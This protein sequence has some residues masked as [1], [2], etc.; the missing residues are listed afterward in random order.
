MTS[1]IESAGARNVAEGDA[2]HL[3]DLET[4]RYGL[5]E[6]ARDMH[7][8]LMR[9]AFSPI[10][11][12]INDCTA[13][14]HMRTENGWEMVA[15]WEGCM[16]HAFTSQH[17]CNFTMNE[18][19]EEHLDDGDVILVNDPW[20]GAIH[21]A[22]INILRPVR[23]NGRAEFVLH[24]TS[25]VVDLGGPI[26][27]GFANGVQTAFEEQLRFPPT[28]LYANDRPVKS[29]FNYLLENVRVPA[30]VLGDVRALN[31]CLVIGERRLRELIGKYDPELVHKGA[32]YGIEMTEAAMRAG[33][34]EIPDGDY[35]AEDV[36]DEDGVTDESVP[37]VMT[38]KKRGDSIE[39]DYSG[40][41]R[42]PLGN[43]GTAWCEAT[44]CIE[45][46]KFIVDP[47]S[48]VNSGTLRPIESILP[49]GSAVCSL[50]PSSVSNHVDIG[51]RIVNLVAQAMGK[52]M[53]DKAI[54]C[55]SGTLG[56]LTLGGVDDRPGHVGNPWASFALAGGGWGATW[57]GDGLTFCTLAIGNCRTSVQEHVE[58]ES[59]LVV[60]QHEIMPDSGGAG[61]HR[62]GNGAVYTITALSETAITVTGDRTR[63]GTPGTKGGG[64]GMPFYGW[65]IPDF[66]AK[67]PASLDVFDLRAAEPL[68]GMFDDKGVPTP[69]GG[70]FG[71]GTKYASA[72]VSGIVLKPGQAIRVII[73]GGGGWGDPLARP[74]ADVLDD[75]LDAMHTRGYSEKAYGVVFSDDTTIDEAATQARRAELAA[76][77]EAGQW[78]VPTACAL[79]WR[80]A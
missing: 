1:T 79:E 8:A 70:T 49:P 35:T 72:K 16:Q 78:S 11:R 73:G 44:R 53:G 31:G 51:G 34:R 41:G 19:D 25:H 75:V 4:I 43:V 22:D 77:R 27:G 10:V 68:F 74:T 5:I 60:V 61:Q 7:Q 21:C 13:A 64:R 32:V 12:D 29:A 67:D 63:I 36:I 57:K 30:S 55:D 26:P 45:G 59:P 14:I 71:L 50:P 23:I 18:W 48:A 58:R 40:T 52:A 33:I 65:L 66:D 47:T 20:R 39:V 17:I 76:A 69:D 80:T 3:I 15:S 37:L 6:V 24:S 28:L 42:Q 9:S 62:G 46:I 38:L 54:G 2:Q 56:M